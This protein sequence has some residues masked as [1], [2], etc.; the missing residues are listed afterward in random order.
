MTQWYKSMAETGMLR[1]PIFNDYLQTD[2]LSTETSD[3][4]KQIIFLQ[5]V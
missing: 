1:L 3:F 5:R 2:I 4:I